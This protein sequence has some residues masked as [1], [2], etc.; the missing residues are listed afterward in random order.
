MFWC[1]HLLSSSSFHSNTLVPNYLFC[2]MISMNPAFRCLAE[3]LRLLLVVS[4]L[5]FWLLL[6]LFLF[7][8]F[9]LFVLFQFYIYLI[10]KDVWIYA[11]LFG[12]KQATFI[13]FYIDTFHYPFKS[14]VVT[15]VCFIF[16]SVSNKY[17]FIHLGVKFSTFVVF[18]FYVALASKNSKVLDIC[19]SSFP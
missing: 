8:F 5:F 3:C 6:I 4:L 2:R 19:W 18:P 15:T 9:L 13:N 14:K 17:D 12:L 7:S 1:L 10:F 11:F 16:T